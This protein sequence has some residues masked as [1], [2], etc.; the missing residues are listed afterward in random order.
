MEDKL[1]IKLVEFEEE[2]SK[3]K[4]AVDFIDAAKTTTEAAGTVVKNFIDLKSEFENL[5]DRIKKLVNEVDKV[6]F[7][8]R[9]DKV[10][11]TISAINS[12][13]SNLQARIESLERNI[14]DALDNIQARMEYLERNI[15]DGLAA[16][17][18]GLLTEMT[19]KY[20]LISDEMHSQ[21][22]NLLI[23]RWIIVFGIVAIVSCLIFIIIK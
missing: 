9:L 3:L 19:N 11:V 22:K 13:I 1:H 8:S 23:N 16:L 15:K 2:L 20:S 17:R 5:S 7:P 10:D 14:K 6:D 4:K 12:N 21:K 18:T